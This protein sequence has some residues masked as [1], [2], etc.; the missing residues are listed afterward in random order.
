MTLPGPYQKGM[1]LKLFP[2]VVMAYA[3]PAT[4]TKLCS[5]LANNK[6]LRDGCS[7]TVMPDSVR[8]KKDDSSWPSLASRL[9]SVSKP[10]ADKYVFKT[11]LSGKKHKNLTDFSLFCQTLIFGKL[12]PSGLKQKHTASIE[13]FT[14]IISK[15]HKV[16]IG[17][18]LV[19][20]TILHTRQSSLEEKL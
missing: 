8:E 12:A 3:D 13:N 7:G 18:L 1:Y 19:S 20:L 6:H 16:D 15:K 14:E 10:A 4:L 5:I 17:M 9:V 2:G 11:N